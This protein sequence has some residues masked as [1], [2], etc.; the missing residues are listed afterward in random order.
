MKRGVQ[1]FS[2]WFS[3]EFSEIY[4]HLR[5]ISAKICCRQLRT[6]ATTFYSPF[7]GLRSSTTGYL[8]LFLLLRNLR[9]N[10]TY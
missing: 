4:F 8:L 9:Q 6:S 10:H 2:L 7:R 1:A 3:V 5:K